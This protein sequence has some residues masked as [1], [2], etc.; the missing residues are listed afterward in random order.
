[1]LLFHQGISMRCTAHALYSTAIH[2]QRSYKK[3]QRVSLPHRVCA[4]VKMPAT[5]IHTE[6]GSTVDI[7]AFARNFATRVQMYNSYTAV[8]LANNQ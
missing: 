1:M 2:F 8:V 6:G 4:L 7:F 5:K 3:K